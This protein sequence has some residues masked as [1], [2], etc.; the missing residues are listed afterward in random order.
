MSTRG[1]LRQIFKRYGCW[2]TLEKGGE[3]YR[4]QAV[5]QPIRDRT[6]LYLENTSGRF[7]VVDKGYAVYYGPNQDGG[8]LL[9]EGDLLTALGKPYL[10]KRCEPYYLEEE[11]VYHWAVLQPA[12]KEEEDVTAD[13]A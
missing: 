10:V 6:K 9:E 12:Y 4:Y 7:G 8:E 1:K 5:I 2:V 13:Q 11:T 3:A